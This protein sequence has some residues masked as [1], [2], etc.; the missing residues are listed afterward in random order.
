VGT[1]SFSP[2]NPPVRLLAREMGF[3][4]TAE[5][6]LATLVKV[7]KLCS[8]VYT[9]T[10]AISD[11]ECWE[12]FQ[13]GGYG[14]FDFSSIFEKSYM[15]MN[16]DN[17]QLVNEDFVRTWTIS[18]CDAKQKTVAVTVKKSGLLSSFLHAV[19]EHFDEMTESPFQVPFR[20]FGGDFR[21]FERNPAVEANKQRN[22][23]V[24]KL[25][26]VAGGIG[27]TPFISFAQQLLGLPSLQVDIIFYFAC[28]GDEV[29]LIEEF[30]ASPAF[31]MTIFNSS[32]EKNYVNENAK[33]ERR[34]MNQSDFS[35][36]LLAD[37]EVFLCGPDA[38]MHDVK[39][40]IG[41]TNS[42]HTENFAF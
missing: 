26:W 21:C 17:P 18:H 11:D 10:F 31:Q 27:I 19:A 34:R 33:L 2:Y 28:R 23:N 5:N 20:G 16:N 7:Q 14:I 8:L 42:I 29:N 41:P 4:S 22:N 24:V 25:L 3:H 6:T 13:F 1:E 37:R 15:H 39:E 9:F 35:S 12:S 38:L 36:S 30:N 40:W 32:L